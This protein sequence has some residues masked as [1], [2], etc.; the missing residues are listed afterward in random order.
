[1]AEEPGDSLIASVGG[2]GPDDRLWRLGLSRRRGERRVAARCWQAV[3][4]LI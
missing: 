4:V 1:M 3:L 2:A